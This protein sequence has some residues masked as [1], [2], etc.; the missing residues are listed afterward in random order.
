MC[1]PKGFSYGQKSVA[2]R[3]S[4]VVKLAVNILIQLGKANEA[5]LYLYFGYEATKLFIRR[6]VYFIIAFV[7]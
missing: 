1:D 5:L 4:E 6:T 7:I 2:Y 3:T